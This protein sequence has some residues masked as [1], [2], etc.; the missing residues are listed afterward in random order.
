MRM[1][2]L[3]KRVKQGAAL[4]MAGLMM[5]SA[6]DLSAVEVKAEENTAEG[7]EENTAVKVAENAPEYMWMF[8]IDIIHDGELQDDGIAD[9]ENTIYQGTNWYYDSIE[10]QLV[11][12]GASISD[13]FCRDGDLTVLLFGE[14][15]LHDVLTFESE[16]SGEEHTLELKGGDN[17]ASLTCDSDITAGGNVPQNLNI[18]G[19]T[20]EMAGKI[21]C[22][23][24]LK[25]ENSR[26]VARRIDCGG[27][28]SIGNSHVIV[29]NDI[30][31][32]IEG[33][34]ITI[35]DS[36]VEAKTSSFGSKA[37]DTNQKINVSDSQIVA[38]CVSVFEKDALG[39]GDFANSVI[40]KQWFDRYVDAVATK[41]YVY[42]TAMLRE[43]L[44]IAS[45]ESID[46]KDGASITNLEKLT[47]EDGATILVDGVEHIH[48]KDGAA[49][50][51]WKDGSEHTKVD[52][53]LD[54]PVGYTW[55]TEAEAHHYNEH[56]SCTECGAYQPAV[57][58]TDK[59]DVNYDDMKESAYEISNAGQ[60][61]WYA[62]LVNGTLPGVGQD[63][64]ANA[65]LTYDIT[66][67]ENVTVDGKLAEDTSG[68]RSWTPIGSEASPYEGIFDGTNHVINGL[69]CN[70][71]S[72]SC[73]A[74]VGYLKH[75]H[76]R[77]LT[78]KDCWISGSTMAAGICGKNDGMV[79]ECYVDG[80]ITAQNDIA[81]GVCGL[82]NF[83]SIKNCYNAAT[84][85]AESLAGGICGSNPT[86]GGIVSCCMNIG[87]V[88]AKSAQGPIYIMEGFQPYQ[89]DI[90]PS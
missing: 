69:F 62:G 71:T 90:N 61:Y 85:A 63:T 15:N 7:T 84:V 75:S 34:E 55:E 23:G 47:V 22:E 58:T 64:A 53:C 57:L 56:G 33:N 25:L 14:N 50:Y 86:G 39:D 82:N 40:T 16:T 8:G 38:C 41:T 21:E 68:F 17:T 4:L 9:N 78:L 54:C 88:T 32:A 52:V 76:V 5:F 77:N 46:F 60:L 12:K 74:F 20:I 51:I 31:G 89:A 18:M 2:R 43:A 44:T 45:G 59:Y 27:S 24:N 87:N 26:V 30:D 37:I 29:N 80:I 67:N 72:M 48:N 35:T 66:L 1:G 10:N 13:F 49:K 73:A 65:V 3:G 79:S 83:G 19:I 28:L 81:G 70:D 11:L 6:V 42:G 36:Y